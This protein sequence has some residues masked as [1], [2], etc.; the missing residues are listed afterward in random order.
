MKYDD[1]KTLPTARA[2]GSLALKPKSEV[3][4]L[5]AEL[6]EDMKKKHA[7]APGR[8]V[9]ALDATA[10]RQNAWDNACKLTADMF[11]EVGAI[12]GLQM[13]LVYYRGSMGECKASEWHA[14]SADL[15]A[16]MT[17]IACAGGYTQIRKVLDHAK[18][19]TTLLKVAAMVFIGD[20]MEEEPDVLIGS[21]AELG[22]LDV[23]VFMFQEGNDPNAER[24]FREIARVTKGAYCPFDPGS[25]RQ[26]SE[27]LRAV[28]VFAA[29]GKTALEARKDASSIK[30][31]TQMKKGE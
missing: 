19:E 4:T 31:L 10:S 24:T 13:Q 15:T 27:L 6:K 2:D 25:A 5:I 23:P 21:A 7:A 3:D 26:L 1:K 9:F 28:A 20:C 17:R 16:V 11:R 8:L 12:G 29:G 18:K 22:R 30:L 14:N